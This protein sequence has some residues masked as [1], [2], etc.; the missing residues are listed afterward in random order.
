VVDPFVDKIW[1]SASLYSS[2]GKIFVIPS[3]ILEGHIRVATP[4]PA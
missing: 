3:D 2:P 4:S 1:C